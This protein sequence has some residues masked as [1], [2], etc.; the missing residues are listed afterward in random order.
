MTASVGDGVILANNV[1]LGGHVRCRRLRL[2][3][4]RRGGAPD[5]A[6]RPAGDGQPAWP[7][8]TQRHPALRLCLRPAGARSSA[9]TRSACCAAARRG[10]QLRTMRDGRTRLLF[11]DPGEFA[12]RLGPR[13][14][15]ASP[16]SRWS[17]RSSPSCRD[18]GRRRQL[19]RPGR[20]A[21]PELGGVDEENGDAAREP[22]A[23]SR[24]ARHHRRRRRAAAARGRRR[25]RAGPP[26]LLPW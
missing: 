20:M 7:A 25:A 23:R 16:A 6:H 13:P 5:R 10:D 19:V 17:P 15:S 22:D 3:R 1:M 4:R 2:R 24:H 18:A 21:A 9:S 11:K 8:S 12:A 26:G 14:T